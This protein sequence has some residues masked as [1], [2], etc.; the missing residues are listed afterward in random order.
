MTFVIG[1]LV[2]LSVGL[3]AGRKHALHPQYFA[4]LLSKVR[5]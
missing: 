2:G 4:T 1:L 5:K 3:W